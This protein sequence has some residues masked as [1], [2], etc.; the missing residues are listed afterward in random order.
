MTKKCQIERVT[1]MDLKDL[2]FFQNV[3][4]VEN[5]EVQFVIITI[6]IS[7]IATNFR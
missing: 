4:T 3:Y 7:G 1:L 6:S 2:M 5:S